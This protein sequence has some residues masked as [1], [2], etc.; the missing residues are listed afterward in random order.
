M[1]YAHQMSILLT[2]E[3]VQ[4]EMCSVC[5]SQFVDGEHAG[6]LRPIGHCHLCFDCFFINGLS[7][8]VTDEKIIAVYV[9]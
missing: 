2:T 4:V 6:Y 5:A 3:S 7:L 1:S 8:P 9:V